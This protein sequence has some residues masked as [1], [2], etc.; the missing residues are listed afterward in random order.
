[1]S[2]VVLNT[3]IYASNIVS[4][5]SIKSN[6]CGR[7]FGSP[8]RLPLFMHTG[9]PVTIR[10]QNIGP[11]PSDIGQNIGRCARYKH[12]LKT[13]LPTGLQVL[14]GPQRHAA[15]NKLYHHKQWFVI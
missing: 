7:P 3:S 11:K 12:Y 4:H 13:S 14:S 6:V 9:F 10:A 8:F 2:T 1:M 15:D 5:V